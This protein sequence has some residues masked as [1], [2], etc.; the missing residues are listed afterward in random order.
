[1]TG[2]ASIL[3]AGR[4]A[5]VLR[6]IELHVEAFFESIGKGFAR[7]IVAVDVLM[8]DRAHGNIRR[9]ELRQVTT[10]AVFVPGKIWP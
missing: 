4:A 5:R 10:G 8:T 7:W 2:S 1:M 9:R 3:R 6:M